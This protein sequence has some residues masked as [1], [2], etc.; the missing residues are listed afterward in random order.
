VDRENVQIWVR[1]KA[2]DNSTQIQ[3]IL[4]WVDGKQPT[5]TVATSSSY[6]KDNV[7]V[8]I[9]VKASE[10]LAEL[11]NV[12]VAENNAPENTQV[13]MTSADNITWT[14]TYTTGDNWLRDGCAT[15]YVIGAQIKDLVGN[16]GVDNSGNFTVDREK[17]P[18]PNLGAIS[19]LPVDM[20]AAT[21]IQTN[22]GQFAPE[23]TALDN[24]LNTIENLENGTVRIRI[25]TTTQDLTAYSTG[26]FITIPAITLTQGTQEIGIRYIDLAGNVGDENAENV[27]YDSIAPVITPNTISGKALVD[28]VIINDNTPTVTL[29]FTDATLGIDNDNFNASDNSGY[30]V[31]L[32]DEND[33]LIATLKNATPPTTNMPNTI[34]F[35]NAYPTVLSDGTYSIYA[36]AGD[37]LQMDNLV[38]SFVVDTKAPAAPAV[39]VPISQDPSSPSIKRTTTV[40][41]GGTCEP[42]ATVRIWT[43]QSPFVSETNVDNVVDT[44]GSGTWTKNITVPEGVEVRIRVSA[45]DLAGN[46]STKTTYG[47]LMVDA[48]A[49]TV[50]IT[51]PTSGTKTDK[52]SISV[53]GT[54]T[55]DAWEDWT[56]IELR[57]QVGLNS[58]PVTISA[59]SF[60]INVPLAE[61]S[62]TIQASVKDPVG[63]TNSSSVTVERTV[64]SWGVYAIILVIIA[65]ILAAIAIFRMR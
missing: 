38:I 29:S 9:T 45:V 65:L 51:T 49:P 8:T 48:T 47:Y 25:G 62:N 32:W 14:G 36:V 22:I 3:N 12:M 26:Y 30:R 59:G 42:Y 23:G 58:T 60:S 21:G 11:D 5:V 31:E 13:T 39:A 53:S 61:G 34:S 2:K 17:P 63:N 55:K 1:T 40:S 46:E 24:F 35:E 37:N 57:V 4:L 20:A 7:V 33:N 41:L 52:A 16:L 18:K 54:V 43:S 19:G 27:T 64:T 10:V 15:V 56:D 50:S 28:G 44:A 6:V